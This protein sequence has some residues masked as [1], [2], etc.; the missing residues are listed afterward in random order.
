MTRM[1]KALAATAIALAVTTVA[2]EASAASNNKGRVSSPN[3]AAAPDNNPGDQRLKPRRPCWVTDTCGNNEIAKVCYYT[4]PYFRGASFCSKPGTGFK[5]L[6]RRWNDRIS[7][8][9]IIGHARTKVCTDAG[10][11]GKCIL[12]NGGARSQLLSMDNAISSLVIYN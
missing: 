11:T 2:F 7:S 3:A 10:M 9:R 12:L 5:Q 1:I 6:G 8:I 4:Q